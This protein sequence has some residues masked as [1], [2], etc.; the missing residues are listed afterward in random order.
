MTNA[1]NPPLNRLGDLMKKAEFRQAFVDNADQAMQSNGV[2]RANIPPKILAA[3]ES[4]GLPELAFLAN[5]G[6]AF[7]DV[8]QS[9]TPTDGAADPAS[10]LRMV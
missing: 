9:S 7:L 6:Q 2:N 1:A 8:S 10:G 4:C 5:V 3:L